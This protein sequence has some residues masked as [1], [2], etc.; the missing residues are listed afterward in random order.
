MI[1]VAI[2][3]GG[4]SAE[5][6]ISLKSAQTIAKHL[7]ADKYR[8]TIIDAMPEGWIAIETGQ[9]VDLN[10]FCLLSDSG[11]ILTRFDFAFLFIHGT[12]VEDGKMKGYFEMMGIPHSACGVLSSALTF[13]KQKALRR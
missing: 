1:E 12:P 6:G 3:A 9:Q 7:P 5:R 2:I 11:D 4:P 8:S 10:R 13:N